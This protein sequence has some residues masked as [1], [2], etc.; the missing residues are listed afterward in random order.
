MSERAWLPGITYIVDS[1]SV[2]DYELDFTDWLD[3]E[4]ISTVAIDGTACDVEQRGEVG[5][6]TVK[7]RVSDVEPGARVIVRVTTSSGQQDVFSV[8]FK[9]KTH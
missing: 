1:Q 4:T 8:N 9:P 2:L 3:G 7:F 5:E 6:N